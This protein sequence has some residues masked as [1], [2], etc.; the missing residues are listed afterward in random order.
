M[1]T[2]GEARAKVKL[3]EKDI[4]SP[5]KPAAVQDPREGLPLPSNRYAKRSYTRQRQTKDG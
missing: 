1:E 2:V 5:R 3:P 4:P